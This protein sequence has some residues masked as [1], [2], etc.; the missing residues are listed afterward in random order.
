MLAVA[1]GIYLGSR[2]GEKNGRKYTIV[3]IG[4]QEEFHTV[5]IFVPQ[6]RVGLLSGISDRQEV[7]L[8]LDVHPGFRGGTSISLRG[9]QPKK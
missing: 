9:I 8:Q 6:D 5:G 2:S 7:E 1:R 3:N 4:C